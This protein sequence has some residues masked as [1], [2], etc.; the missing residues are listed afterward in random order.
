MEG[1]FSA[2]RVVWEALGEKLQIH[3]NFVLQVLQCKLQNATNKLDGLVGVQE[4]IST[5]DKIM[6]KRGS[7]KKLKYAAYAKAAL[8]GIIDDLEKWQRMFDPSWFFLARITVPVID[9]QLTEKTAANSKAISTV[10]QLRQ[11]HEANKKGSASSTPIF[12]QGGHKVREQESI[13]FSSAFTGRILDQ[14]VITDHIP[15]R[16]QADLDI[17]T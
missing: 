11:A 4:E 1:Q 13:V 3:Q 10:V 2:L 7:A 9:Q 14:R 15:V 8:D 16:E 5:W 12:L 6:A 17:A